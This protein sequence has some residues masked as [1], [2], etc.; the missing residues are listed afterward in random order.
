MITGHFR[1]QK[2]PFGLSNEFSFF[3]FPADCFH[4]NIFLI[5]G[6]FFHLVCYEFI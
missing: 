1:Q 3:F 4:V 5:T 2:G 6:H